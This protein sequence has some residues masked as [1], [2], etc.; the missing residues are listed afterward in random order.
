[1]QSESTPSTSA[2]IIGELASPSA[3]PMSRLAALAQT[4]VAF[5]HHNYRLYFT[6][7]IISQIGNWMQMT[8]QG[9]LVYELTRSAGFL[10]V[11]S[12]ASA[13]PVLLLS[14]AAGVVVD[15]WPRRTVL[16]TTKVGAM[17]V[18]FALAALV[19]WKVVE[20]W[21]ILVLSFLLGINNAFEGTARQTFVKDMVGKD[22]MTNA[23]AMN[24]VSFNSSRIIGPTI[25]GVLI[26]AIGPGWCFFL[27]GVGYIAALTSL[28]MM[29]LPHT[30]PPPRQASIWL[31][32]K[33]GLTYIREH[34]T[35]RTLMLVVVVSSIFGFVYQ[36]LLPAYVREV[37]HASTQD[38]AQA[39]GFLTSMA[40]IGSLVGALAVASLG[41]SKRRGL[42]LT[43][44]NFVF[45]IA[46]M[47][48]AVSQWLPLSALALVAV[49]LGL[50]VQ[51]T[52]A[53]A[54]VQSN[55]PDHLRG[56]V[57]SVYMLCFFGMT[58]IGSLQGGLI[59]Q[60]FGVPLAIGFG[61]TVTL[62]FSLFLLWR[63][64]YVREL[65]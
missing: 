44:G 42:I 36:A 7:G 40:G 11:V 16:A 50:M 2:T 32:I 30:P 52:T 17:G 6:G 61:G 9:W 65:T 63:M 4:F 58:P 57:M 12:F 43:F 5:R 21:H 59:A 49:S 48:L 26:Y 47:V 51:S 14:L 35:I 62:L 34:Q 15:R 25:A 13:L 41:Q 1:M 23:I 28:V 10:G 53:N 19:L 39:Q 38:S 64:R 56:R 60:Y 3:Q 18:S 29:R 31:E 54:L 33:E 8:T 46:L 22:D 27:T 45:P 24:S 55:V 20:P 37:L